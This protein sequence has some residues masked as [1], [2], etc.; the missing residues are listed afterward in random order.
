MAERGGFGPPTIYNKD[1]VS[2]GVL[3]QD[4]THAPVL[5]PEVCEIRDAW[6]ALPEHIR[7]SILALV[8]SVKGGV[9]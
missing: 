6:K 3:T 1:R 2:A 9:L 7:L 4:L 5:P 8:R